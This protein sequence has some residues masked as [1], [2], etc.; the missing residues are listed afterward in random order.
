MKRTIEQ[1][2][3]C[4]PRSMAYHQSDNAKQFGFEDAKHDILELYEALKIARDW[5]VT[6]GDHPEGWSV[7]RIDEILGIR[8][9]Y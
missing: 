6:G 4:D 2:K 9:H 1:W 5:L 3:K 7:S 8:P